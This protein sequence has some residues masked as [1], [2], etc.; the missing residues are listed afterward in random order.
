M[1]Q[2]NPPHAQALMA[3]NCISSWVVNSWLVRMNHWS[4]QCTIESFSEFVNQFNRFERIILDESDITNTIAT[5]L[6]VQRRKQCFVLECKEKNINECA[7]K[8]RT[9]LKK[10]GY[11]KKVTNDKY[12]VIAGKAGSLSLIVLCSIGLHFQSITMI[13]SLIKG[14]PFLQIIR[15]F[16]LIQSGTGGR[17]HEDRHGER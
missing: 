11:K 15:S 12:M 9:L 8:N 3:I 16:W 10:K 5:C 6:F 17:G 2:S 13:W 7:L 4:V 14:T 1:S